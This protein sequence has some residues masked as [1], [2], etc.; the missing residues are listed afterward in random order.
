MSPSPASSSVGLVP[1]HEY[2]EGVS[3]SDVDSDFYPAPCWRAWSS[4]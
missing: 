2:V 3:S 4:E 1:L